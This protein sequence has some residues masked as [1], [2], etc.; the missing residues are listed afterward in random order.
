MSYLKNYINLYLQGSNLISIFN[1]PARRLTLKEARRQL[2]VEI[3][4]VDN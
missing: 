4:F 3:K 2:T 1:S